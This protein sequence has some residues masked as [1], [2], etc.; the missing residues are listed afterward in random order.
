MLTA[1]SFLEN[2]KH[3]CFSYLNAT[4]WKKYFEKDLPNI[5]NSK[6]KALL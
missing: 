1:P 4:N 5:K 3:H 2:I 6:G